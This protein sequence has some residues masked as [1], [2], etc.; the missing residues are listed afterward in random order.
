MRSESLKIKGFTLYLRVK[1]TETLRQ[2][3]LNSTIKLPIIY[4]KN[5][6]F[7]KGEKYAKN[8]KNLLH[9][10]V[11]KTQII[12]LGEKNTQIMYVCVYC[13]PKYIKIIENP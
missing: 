5:T 10:G 9:S 3:Y 1:N 4:D 8:T 7:T 2:K 13:S 11:K 6:R 12:Y